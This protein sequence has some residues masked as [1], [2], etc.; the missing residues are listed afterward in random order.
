MRRVVDNPTE[1]QTILQQLHNE[2]GH[3]ERKGIY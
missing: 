2:S 1:R 3:K